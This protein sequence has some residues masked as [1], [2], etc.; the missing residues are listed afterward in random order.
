[1]CVCVCMAYAS[2]NYAIFAFTELS[3]FYSSGSSPRCVSKHIFLHSLTQTGMQS[4]HTGW[5]H[6][7]KRA[8]RVII[9]WAKEKGRAH[10]KHTHLVIQACLN[11]HVKLSFV[12]SSHSLFLPGWLNGLSTDPQASVNAGC[13][14]L[15]FQVVPNCSHNKVSKLDPALGGGGVLQRA[16]WSPLRQMHWCNFSVTSLTLENVNHWFPVIYRLF[17]STPTS[18]KPHIIKWR[19]RLGLCLY[20]NVCLSGGG[21]GWGVKYLGSPAC[22]TWPSHLAYI[23]APLIMTSESF[24]CVQERLDV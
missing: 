21:R 19:A 20:F 17:N 7:K 3:P 14:I 10:T 16:P 12:C 4:A 15:V 5:G 23:L 11:H 2:C 22:P 6:E 8:D 1:M 18:S 24:W 9:A 13:R